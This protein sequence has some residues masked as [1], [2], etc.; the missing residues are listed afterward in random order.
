[1]E[2]LNKYFLFEIRELLDNHIISSELNRLNTEL[3]I[4]SSS[5]NSSTR[6]ADALFPKS[7]MLENN[8]AKDRLQIEITIPRY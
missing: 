1:M 3:E 8:F 2:K 6:F 7:I 5:V 4:S